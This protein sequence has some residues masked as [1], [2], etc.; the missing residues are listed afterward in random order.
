MMDNYKIFSVDIRGKRVFVTNKPIIFNNDEERLIGAI[1]QHTGEIDIK[2][3]DVTDP[4]FDISECEIIDIS[5]WE[6]EGYDELYNKVMS[7]ESPG[8]TK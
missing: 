5:N 2:N 3:A 6:Y 8:K 7:Y 1:D 4:G